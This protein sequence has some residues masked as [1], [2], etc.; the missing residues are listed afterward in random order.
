MRRSMRIAFAALVAALAACA[1]RATASPDGRPAQRR[2]ENMLY[3]E[4]IAG[5]R[6]SDAYEAILSLRPRFLAARAMP[7]MHGGYGVRIV[8]DG[9]TVPEDG[10][11]SVRAE[12]I[13]YVRYLSAPE[14]TTY[15]GTGF[16]TPVVYVLTRAGPGA[17]AVRR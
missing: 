6:A 2:N 13:V 4:E 12:E 9:L 5:A 1:P 8:V 15:W 3:A 16:N 10:L 17:G 7:N 11:R 14:A